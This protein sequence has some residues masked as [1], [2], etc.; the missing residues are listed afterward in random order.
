MFNATKQKND[1]PSPKRKTGISTPFLAK[2]S[3]TMLVAS[4]PL[5][6]RARSN[7]PPPTTINEVSVNISGSKARVNFCVKMMCKAKKRAHPTVMTSPH[8][9]DR[10]GG[11][12]MNP[13]PTVAINTPQ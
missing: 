4:V 11:P 5:D 3:L 12:S 2:T 8:P 13:A 9:H 10:C 6:A 7:E 1:P